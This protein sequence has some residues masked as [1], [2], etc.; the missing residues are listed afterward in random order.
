MK[1]GAL[2][3]DDS[4]VDLAEAKKVLAACDVELDCATSSERADLAF[5]PNRHQLLIVDWHLGESSPID[6]LQLAETL[7]ARARSMKKF[8]YVILITGAERMSLKAAFAA[9]PGCYTDAGPWTLE[10]EAGAFLCRE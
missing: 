5:A 9:E 7:R 1:V 2:L 3:V 10:R 4:P 8:L 6:G